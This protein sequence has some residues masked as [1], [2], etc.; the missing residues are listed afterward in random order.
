[1]WQNWVSENIFLNIT[2]VNFQTYRF[3]T[4]FSE[5]LSDEKTK[6][7]GIR[8]FLMKPVVTSDMAKMVRKVLNEAKS[9]TQQ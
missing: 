1:M 6:T 2:K 8:G 5:R 7:I 9:I 3:C 4:G